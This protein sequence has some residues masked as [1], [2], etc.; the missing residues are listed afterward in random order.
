MLNKFVSIVIPTHNRKNLLR[1]CLLSLRKQN[2]DKFRI[3][4][5]DDGSTDGT[6]KMLKEYFKETIILRGDGN[7]W[8]TKS[9]NN[10]I[11]Y[12]LKHIKRTDYIILLND[13]TE[14]HPNYIL[15]LVKDAIN[16]PKSIIGS[17]AVDINNPEKIVWDGIESKP[18]RRTIRIN[19]GEKLNKVKSDI[20]Y[21]SNKLIGR[22]VIY[23]VDV[24]YKVGFFDDKH[25]EQCGDTELP[26]RAAL[27]GYKL[28]VSNNAIVY[29]YTDETSGIN[30]KK[31]YQGYRLRDFK[32]KFFSIKSNTRFRYMFFYRWNTSENIIEFL[33]SFLS[34]VLITVFH[35]FLK[36][37]KSF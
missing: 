35:G 26:G 29:T 15:N 21:N 7:L 33:Y 25:F 1:N 24:F 16:H 20:I 18:F 27:N 3:I 13:D 37:V 31:N 36:N 34:D 17:V 22:G 8:W 2:Y 5:V 12:A 9:V 10:G 6:H 30:I 23:P 28:L 19:K 4:I 14:V 32:E 11:K